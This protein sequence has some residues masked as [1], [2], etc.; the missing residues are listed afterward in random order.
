MLQVL[1]GGQ[2][3]WLYARCQQM[4]LVVFVNCARGNTTAA[5]ALSCC[6]CI[7]AASTWHKSNAQLDAGAYTWC[8]Y[9]WVYWTI[10]LVYKKRG[11][12]LDILLWPLLLC[13]AWSKDSAVCVVMT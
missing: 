6:A 9:A 13:S 12:M 8:I 1:L 7:T 2:R 4:V 3:C 10:Y 11:D 5:G